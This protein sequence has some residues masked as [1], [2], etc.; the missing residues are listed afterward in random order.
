MIKKRNIYLELFKQKS[1]KRFQFVT[2][3]PEKI[4]LKA[5]TIV[6]FLSEYKFNYLRLKSRYALLS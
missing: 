6:I 1:N 5:I 3:N 2:N 4:L